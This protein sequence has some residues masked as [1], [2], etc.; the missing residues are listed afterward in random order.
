MKI[1]SEVCTRTHNSTLKNKKAPHRG[2]GDT[3]LPNPPPPPPPPRALC[4]L[5]GG[6]Q[7]IWNAPCGISEVICHLNLS[8]IDVLVFLILSVLFFQAKFNAS[9]LIVLRDMLGTDMIFHWHQWNWQMHFPLLQKHSLLS[10][11]SFCQSR[12]VLMA[13]MWRVGNLIFFFYIYMMKIEMK[14]HPGVTVL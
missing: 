9:A 10:L 7:E 14:H 1:P 2:R 12:A 8:N 3:P 11:A 6:F 13:C 5:A 4:S